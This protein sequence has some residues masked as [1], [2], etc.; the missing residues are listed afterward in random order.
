M[1]ARLGLS[2]LALLTVVCVGLACSSSQQP[3][4]PILKPTQVIVPE[5]LIGLIETLTLTVY[6]A[7]NDSGAS[8]TCDP[9]TGVISGNLSSAD[10]LGSTSSF[11][12]CMNGDAFCTNPMMPLAIADSKTVP[13]IFSAIGYGPGMR[14]VAT[15]CIQTMLTPGETTDS[16]SI[17]FV[18]YVP[19]VKCNA[20]GSGTVPFTETCIDTTAACNSTTCQ[21]V[22]QLVSYANPSGGSMTNMGTAGQMTNPSFNWGTGTFVAVYSDASI[23]GM[24]QIT[25]RLLDDT[26]SPVSASAYN[27]V[28]A[29]SSFY[30][31]SSAGTFPYSASDD[32]DKEPSVAGLSGNVYVAFS[33]AHE[34]GATTNPFNICLDAFAETSSLPGAGPCLVSTT[35]STTVQSY[36]SIAAGSSALYVAWVDANGSVFGTLL[37]PGSGCP[38]AGAITSI[39]SG[40]PTSSNLGPSVAAAG[41]GWVVVWPNGTSIEAQLINSDGSMNGINENVGTGSTPSVGAVPGGA[42]F[43]IAWAGLSGVQV[44]RYSVSGGGA[45]PMTM[46]D[47]K[48]TIN[49]A[50]GDTIGTPAIAGGSSAGGFYAVTWVDEPGT[51]AANVRAR[52]VNATSG[53]LSDDSGYFFNFVDGLAGDFQVNIPSVDGAMGR[54]PNPTSPVVAVGGASGEF[55]AFGWEDRGS[56]CPMPGLPPG[57]V[58]CWGI[59]TRRFPVPFE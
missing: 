9:T 59:I 22:E 34:F 39:G 43:A 25:A 40:I 48:A 55:I 56:T 42:N 28:A 29:S 36:P 19:Q 13:R 11:M 6:A 31:P 18:H 38:T 21:T 2:L 26:L 54:L 51:S 1:R 35:Q 49:S 14:E 20:T 45:T 33:C 7:D 15:G 37:T 57:G 24:P 52:Y 4:G 12:N 41:S 16:V 58:P 27:E 47:A 44:Q 8:L 17:T 53:D 3:K 23:S 46:G 5:D 30:V 32:L 50:A 10:N